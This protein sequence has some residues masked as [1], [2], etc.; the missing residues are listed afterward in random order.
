MAQADPTHR[1][2]IDKWLWAARFF[3]T[4]TLAVE[5]CTRGHVKLNGTVVKP[6]REVRVDDWLLLRN[7]SGEYELRIVALSEVRGPA[8]AAQALYEETEASRVERAR[9]AELQR[10][11]P[12]PEATRHG[13]PSKRDRR[14]LDAARSQ[15]RD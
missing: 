5:A 13:R 11:Q 10:L 1:V 15:R 8:H 12:E 7:P 2:R 6:A 3:K 14:V 9:L 4:R